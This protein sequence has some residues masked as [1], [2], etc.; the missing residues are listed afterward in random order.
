MAFGVVETTPISLGRSPSFGLWVVSTTLYSWFG[1]GRTTLWLPTHKGVAGPPPYRLWE[2]APA[3]FW[4]KWLY[5]IICQ[6]KKKKK[7]HPPTR[8]VVGGG[9]SYPSFLSFSLKKKKTIFIFYQVESFS[10]VLKFLNFNHCTSW[11]GL[12]PPQNNRMRIKINM[13]FFVIPIS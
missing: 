12:A 4:P 10:H 5:K 6:K 11:D 3:T 7:G 2:V 8:G 9:S 13:M 1:G